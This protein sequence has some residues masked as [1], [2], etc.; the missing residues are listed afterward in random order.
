MYV[1]VCSEDPESADVR[2]QCIARMCKAFKCDEKVFHAEFNLSLVARDIFIH[3][4]CSTHDAWQRAVQQTSRCRSSFPLTQLGPV[5]E[6]YIAWAIS[7]SGVEQTLSLRKWVSDA[8][9]NS[10]SSGELDAL[11]IAA[12]NYPAEE[13]QII[14]DARSVWTQLYGAPRKSGTRVR[15][16][17]R[18]RSELDKDGRQ[19]ETAWLK[20]RRQHVD[21]LM[22]AESSPKKLDVVV[23]DAG[24]LAAPI[25]AE[26]HEKEFAYQ[27]AC[28]ELR[29]LEAA[30]QG[31]ALD[32]E[33]DSDNK[34]KLDEWVKHQ[35]T[36]KRGREN[37]T[38]RKQAA[39]ATRAA[40]RSEGLVVHVQKDLLK[41]AIV[42]ST[43]NK[44]RM[45]RADVAHRSH[46]FVVN[47]VLE[48]GPSRDWCAVL[49]VP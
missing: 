30:W 39:V 33:M 14:L 9:T 15:G 1:N 25:W 20:R 18:A 16:V 2:D 12:H 34:A 19:T 40:L 29:F 36:L 23:R 8:R 3:Q 42:A 46:M 10:G 4:G 35:E 49:G 26:S 41:P 28:R 7:S 27:N 11:T 21:N 5:L 38:S 6:R 43:L 17:K 44:F 32:S 13:K 45:L 48:P 31:H 24:A 47:N 22:V 37:D